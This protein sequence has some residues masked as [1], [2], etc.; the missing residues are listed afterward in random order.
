[1]IGQLSRTMPSFI[2]EMMD[3]IRVFG[4][5]NAHAHENELDRYRQINETEIRNK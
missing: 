1:M 5:S 2:T 3:N 4:N